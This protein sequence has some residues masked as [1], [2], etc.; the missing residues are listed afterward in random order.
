MVRTMETGDG[1]DGPHVP[2]RCPACETTTR[3]ALDEV[4]DAVA[5]H[6]EQ[7]HDGESVAQVD[8]DVADHLLDLVAEDMGLSGEDP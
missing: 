1:D 2:V 8:P 6:N 3:V 7:L 5:R 4:A